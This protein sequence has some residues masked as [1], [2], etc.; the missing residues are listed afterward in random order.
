MHLSL[1]LFRKSCIAK[2]TRD[3][4][5]GAIIG[6][7]QIVHK[8]NEVAPGFIIIIIIIIIIIKFV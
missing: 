6:F 7:E 8:V 2:V 4:L 1:Q 5:E 3:N